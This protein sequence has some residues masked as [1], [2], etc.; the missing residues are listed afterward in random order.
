MATLQVEPARAMIDEPVR[1]TVRGL[2]PGQA[3]TMT[4]AVQDD[5]PLFRSYSHY[6]ADNEGQIDLDIHA[7]S[8]GTYEGMK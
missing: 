5:G 6:M 7:S 8:S 1:I 2:K 3:V 4:A